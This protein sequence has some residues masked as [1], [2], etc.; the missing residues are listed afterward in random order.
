MTREQLITS[1]EYVVG[2]FQLGLLNLIEGYMQKKEINRKELS[3]EL[4]VSKGYVSQLLNVSYDHKI[5]KLVELALS[6]NYM[7]VLNFVELNTYVDNDQKD[8]VYE[9]VSVERDRDIQYNTITS[10]NENDINWTMDTKIT[11]V[12]QMYN[13]KTFKVND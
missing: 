8:R 10:S 13:Y 3:D 2:K 4:S 9:L 1:K 12:I 11:P 6:C 7:P 5:S